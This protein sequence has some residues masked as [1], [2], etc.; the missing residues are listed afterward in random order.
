MVGGPS[1]VLDDIVALETKFQERT[2]YSGEDAVLVAKPAPLHP[3][4]NWGRPNQVP[5][6]P[7]YVLPYFRGMLAPSE[8]TIINIMRRHFLGC[9]GDSSEEAASKWSTW[10][11]GVKSWH[12][13]EAGREILHI[14][15]AINLALEAQARVF[16]IFAHG[17]YLG[18]AIIGYRFVIWNKDQLLLPDTPKDVRAFAIGLDTHTTKLETIRQLLNRLS[19]RSEGMSTDL[20]LEELSSGRNL[21]RRINERV[22]PED[23]NDMDALVDAVDNLAFGEDYWGV[24]KERVVQA[25]NA[26]ITDEPV[27]QEWPMY[28][29]SNHLYDTSV[30]YQVLSAF[31][32]T[33]PSFVDAGGN[34]FPIPR[35][36]EAADPASEKDQSGQ[37]NLPSIL[38]S[39]KKITLAVNDMTGVFSKRRIRQNLAE[40]ASGFRTIRFKG[41]GRNAIWNA[42]KGIPYEVEKSKKRKDRDEDE[43]GPGESSK[44]AKG[45]AKETVEMDF[46]AFD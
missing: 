34:D 16:L 42:L 28:L 3:E 39:C 1:E 32:P 14:L 43:G 11:K 40:R 10:V 29:S 8:H 24:T 37:M 6:L 2:S 23:S 35:G 18:A 44:R 36:L 38:V 17:T 5:N 45:K 25:I 15:M 9:F 4:V 41:E 20:T 19:L 26:M 33:A 7:G 46:S 22:K 12:R 27:P 21:Y 13:T 31:G 30:F